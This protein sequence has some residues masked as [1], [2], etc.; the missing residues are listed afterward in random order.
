MNQHV[1]PAFLDLPSG[2]LS[3]RQFQTKEMDSWSMKGSWCE[4]VQSSIAVTNKCPEGQHRKAVPYVS[5][6]IHAVNGIASRLRCVCR[7]SAPFRLLVSTASSL[8]GAIVC[9]HAVM[10]FRGKPSKACQRC[11]DRRLKVRPVQI[12]IVYR[13][14]TSSSAIFAPSHV[15]NA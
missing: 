1:T 10:P 2:S 3:S 5:A 12:C 8:P 7:K 9:R 11:R 13:T 4:Y 6:E 15:G 14:L